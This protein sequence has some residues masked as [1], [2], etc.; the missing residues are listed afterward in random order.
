[1][2]AQLLEKRGIGARVVPSEAVTGEIK[3]RTCDVGGLQQFRR[4]G[5]P[6]YSL[7]NNIREIS[8]GMRR[9]ESGSVI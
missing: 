2:L 1:M 3:R 6:G 5:C 7:I 9:V 8:V 4:S